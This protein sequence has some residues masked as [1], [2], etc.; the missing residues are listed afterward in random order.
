MVMTPSQMLPLGTMLPPTELP[1]AAG[2]TVRVQPGARGL[3]VV[4]MCNHCP[5]VKL[6]RNELAKLGRDCAEMGVT[7]VGINANDSE[8][9]PDDSP[10]KMLLE[11]ENYDYTFPYLV[12]AEQTTAQAFRA[13][14][15]P[16]FY[17][18]DAHGALVY[19]GQLD[20]ARPGN[21]VDVT[22]HDLRAA[23]DALV[24]GQPPLATQ[25]PSIGCNIKWIPGH[26]PDYFG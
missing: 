26:E 2:E 18:F 19:R 8:R 17:L 23:L 3:L 7:M 9:Y 20:D 5:Y 12:D 15:T 6:I 16:D 13:A 14:C 21:G 24:K 4:F 11:A 1:T 10:A 22:G 25:K